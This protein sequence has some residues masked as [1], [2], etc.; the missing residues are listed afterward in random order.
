M[1]SLPGVD[2]SDVRYALRTSGLLAQ[3][4]RAGVL[5]SADAGTRDTHA[6]QHSA[7]QNWHPR[8]SSTTIYSIALDAFP[9]LFLRFRF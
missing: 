7:E 8:L 4:N 9:Y 2:A 6:E 3:F 5:N 1:T